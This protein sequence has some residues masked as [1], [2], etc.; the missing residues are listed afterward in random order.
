[1]S[2]VHEVSETFKPREVAVHLRDSDCTVDP[3][4]DLCTGCD[5]D[6]SGQC[7]GC[8]QRGY[9]TAACLDTEVT[10]VEADRFERS[11]ADIK[12]ALHAYAYNLTPAVRS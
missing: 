6:H 9:H 10:A 11:I 12:N 8:L 2:K 1:V 4:T 3:A 7:P 5:V